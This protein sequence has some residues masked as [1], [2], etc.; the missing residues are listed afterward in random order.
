MEKQGGGAGI[1][2]KL[3]EISVID[4]MQTLE[5]GRKSC[6]LMLR[7]GGETCA[8]YFSDGSVTHAVCGDLK[9][10]AAVFKALTWMDGDWEVDFQK[11]SPEHTTTMSTQGL[12]ME[13]LRIFDEN[14]R[15]AR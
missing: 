14:N 1:K 15:E 7:S 2:G 9:G 3:S 6:A 13:G 8:V 12:M 11:N 4:W 5:Q 10:D